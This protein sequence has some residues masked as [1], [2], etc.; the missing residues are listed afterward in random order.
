MMWIRY[1]V[2]ALFAFCGGAIVAGGVFTVLLAI[3]LVPRFAGKTHT[4]KKIYLY[5]EMIVL[6]TIFGSFL[7]IYDRLSQLGRFMV[8][9][10]GIDSFVWQGVGTV[11]LIICGI[12]SGMFVGSLALATAEMLDTIPIFT[13]RIHFQKGLGIMVCSIAVGKVIGSL[14]YFIYGFMKGVA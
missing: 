11:L 9:N 4:A 10:I 8:E 14:I 2:M 13:R 5:E 3:G 1:V 12:F 6:G 7:S